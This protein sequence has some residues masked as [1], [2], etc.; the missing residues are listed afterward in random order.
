MQLDRLLFMP[1]ISRLSF[2]FWDNCLGLWDSLTQGVRE[3]VWS[4]ALSIGSDSSLWAELSGRL[5]AC[6]SKTNI[7]RP[8]AYFFLMRLF[9]GGRGAAEGSKS[10]ARLSCA[11][12]SVTSPLRSASSTSSGHVSCCAQLRAGQGTGAGVGA[13]RESSASLTPPLCTCRK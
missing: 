12:E 8:S 4:A 1:V 2:K 13:T 6:S 7:Y 3:Q 11:G 5:A 9:F 10:S